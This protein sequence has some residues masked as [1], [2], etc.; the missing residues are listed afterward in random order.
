MMNKLLQRALLLIVLGGGYLLSRAW[1]QTQET[2][3]TPQTRETKPFGGDEAPEHSEAKAR[4][5]YRPLVPPTAAPDAPRDPANR[6]QRWGSRGGFGRGMGRGMGMGMMRGRGP[7]RMSEEEMQEFEALSQAVEKLKS[8]K[9]DSEKTSA[10]NE[11]SQVL[12]KWFKR[13]LER[14][15][16][17]I[18]EI[19]TRVKK[20]RDQIEK[21]KKAK[22]EIIN[23]RVK[24]IVNEANGLGFPGAFEQESAA[25]PFSSPHFGTDLPHFGTDLPPQMGDVPFGDPK[26]PNPPVARQPGDKSP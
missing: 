17:Q 14:R 9:N 1:A 11:I 15:E 12:E 7:R 4:D 24:T 5:E 2:S 8:A 22:D 25:D 3:K 13:D 16:S 26:P 21:R 23:L 18:S 19:E 10:T 6:V 20:L